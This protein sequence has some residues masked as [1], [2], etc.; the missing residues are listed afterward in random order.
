MS[1]RKS[2]LKQYNLLPA[3]D[4]SQATLTSQVCNI[5][6]LDNIGIQLVFT[7]TP[8][9]TFQV[10]ISADYNQDNYGNVLNAGDWTPI[11]LSSSPVA[12][13]SAGNVYIDMAELSAPWLRVVYT[14]VSGTGTLN[15]WVT[16]KMV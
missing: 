15:V 9:G 8:T 2:N 3:G 11:T 16:G 14:K 6:Q 12:S 7:G 4:M 5:N 1:G 10:Q 13:G